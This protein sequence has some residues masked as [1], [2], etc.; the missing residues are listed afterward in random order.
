[1]V[2]SRC[3]RQNYVFWGPLTGRGGGERKIK[4]EMVFKAELRKKVKGA[5]MKGEQKLKGVSEGKLTLTRG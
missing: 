2:K 3:K 5:K 1:V 4:R